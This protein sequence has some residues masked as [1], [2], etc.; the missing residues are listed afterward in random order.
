MYT[1]FRP[2]F[3]LVKG[4][5]TVLGSQQFDAKTVES[6]SLRLRLPSR[7]DLRREGSR[8]RPC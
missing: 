7:A 3:A 1:L 6:I 2:K 5:R 8:D 4:G